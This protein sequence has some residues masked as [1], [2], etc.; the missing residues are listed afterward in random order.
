MVSA[1]RLARLG[2]QWLSG[3]PQA[4]SVPWWAGR[5]STLLTAN[6]KQGLACLCSITGSSTHLPELHRQRGFI[7]S[8]QAMGVSGGEV[9]SNEISAALKFTSKYLIREMFDFNN[10]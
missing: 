10:K 2:L 5:A 9:R 6:D 3:C 4:V 7:F 1:A 8:A